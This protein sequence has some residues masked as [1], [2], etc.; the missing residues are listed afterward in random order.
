MIT[1]KNNKDKETK[2]REN[3]S[4]ELGEIVYTEKPEKYCLLGIG[5]CLFIEIYDDKLKRFALAHT[6]LPTLKSKSGTKVHMSGRYT[7]EAIESM[8]EHLIKKGSNRRNLRVKIV[9]GGRIYNNKMH[10]GERNI[11][12]AKK[13]LYEVGLKI[14]RM[15][16]GGDVGRSVLAV[17]QNGLLTLRKNGKVYSI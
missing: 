2:M 15:D 4:L 11:E 5:T 6:V 12:T 3:R 13:K 8:V 10:I 17:N 9:G 1:A 16:V 7:D 14:S